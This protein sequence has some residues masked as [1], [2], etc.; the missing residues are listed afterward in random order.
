MF[1]S[2]L[3]LSISRLIEG[4][5]AFSTLK[6]WSCVFQSREFHSCDLVPRFPV[7]RFQRPRPNATYNRKVDVAATVSLIAA[8]CSEDATQLF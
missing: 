2:T 1:L 7:A 4:G 5:R 6:I 8:I 3:Y